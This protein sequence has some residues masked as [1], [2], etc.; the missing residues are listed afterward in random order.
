MV[1]FLCENDFRVGGFRGFG[2]KKFNLGF[3]CFILIKIIIYCIIEVLLILSIK[4]M[5]RR[6]F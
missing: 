3:Y 4:V 1:F 5:Y 6:N 2:L